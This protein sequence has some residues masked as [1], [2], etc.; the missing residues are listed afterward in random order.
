MADIDRGVLASLAGSA[1]ASAAYTESAADLMT[2]PAVVIGPHDRIATAAKL[3]D[4]ESVKRLPVVDEHGHL[5]GIVS[6]PS[7]KA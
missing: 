5:V 3:M 6:R 2:A 4:A 1:A 7:M